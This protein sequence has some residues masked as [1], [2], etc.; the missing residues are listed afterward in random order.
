MAGICHKSG[1]VSHPA[2]GRTA[3]RDRA[4]ARALAAGQSLALEHRAD[5]AVVLSGTVRAGDGHPCAACLAGPTVVLR[6]DL[7]RG[8]VHVVH[9]LRFLSMDH[10][11]C[12]F[13][14]AR[15]RAF[16]T[17][18][19]DAMSARI[20]ALADTWADLSAHPSHMIH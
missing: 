17:L 15:D 11:T 4:D 3:V 12:L 19:L 14:I 7:R 10:Q 1:A 5:L 2:Q 8:P 16:R 18:F 20:R 6:S 9:D 13:L